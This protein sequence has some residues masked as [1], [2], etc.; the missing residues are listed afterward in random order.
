MSKA[1]EDTGLFWEI[2]KVFP[3]SK[4]VNYTEGR[5][6]VKDCS[7]HTQGIGCGCRGNKKGE[8]TDGK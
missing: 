1:N 2:F 4:I 8:V 3:G 6:D 7:C 5:K